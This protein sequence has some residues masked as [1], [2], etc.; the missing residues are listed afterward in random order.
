VR[1]SGTSTPVEAAGAPEAGRPDGPGRGPDRRQVTVLFADLTGFTALAERI[2]AEEI[3]AFQNALFEMLAGVITRYD[4]FVE[5]FVGDAVLAVFGAP[6]AHEDDPLRACAAALS[7]VESGDT[8]T[9]HWAERLGQPVTLHV[10]IHTGPVV[11]GNLSGAAGAAYAVTGDTVNTTARLLAAAA[12]GTIL[13]SAVTHAHVRHRFAFEPAGELPLRGKTEAV[14][15]HRLLGAL[16]EPGSARGLTGLGLVAP[17][18]GRV[19]ELD[20]L[21]AAFDRM[22]RRRAQVV[23]VVGEAGTGKS[24]LI[25][26][27]LSRLEVDGRLSGVAVRGAACSSLGESPYGV[28]GALFRA[29]YGVKATD[30]LDV[31]RQKLASGLRALGARDDEVR[32]IAPVLSYVLG[33]EEVV[34]S[35]IEPE[36]LQR[37]IA[38]AAR[39]LI[40]WRL[41]NQPLLIVIEDLH[42]ADAASVDVL[43]HVVDQLADRPLMV[44]VSHRPDTQPPLVA[45]AAQAVVQVSPLTPDETRALVAGLFGASVDV[46]ERVQEFIAARA[47][48]NPFFTEEIVRSLVGKGVLVRESDRWTCTAACEAVDVPSTLQ[49]LLL[50]RVDRLPVEPRRLLQ[51]AAVLGVVFDDTLLGAVAT[52]VGGLDAALDRLVE[53]DLIQTDGPRPEEGRYRFTHALVR[54]VV[55]QNLLVSRRSEMHERVGR[56]LEQAVGSRPER[57][58]D[59]EALGHHWSLSAD[60]VRG[61]RY[62]VTAGDRARAVY[63]ND[64]AIRHYERALQILAECPGCE[65]DARAAREQL[66]DLLGLTGRRAEALGQYEAVRKE[67][68][69]AADRVAAARVQRKLGGLQ[70]EAGDRERAGACFAAGLDLLGEDGDPIERAHLF[71]EMGR[72]AFR[73]GDNAAAIAWAERALAEAAH[74]DGAHPERTREADAMCAQAYN[75]LGVALARTGRLAEAVEQIERSIELSEARDLLQAACRGYTNL[76]VLYSSLDPRRSIETCLRGLETAKKVGDL[77]FQSRL[78]ANLAVAY[79]ALTDRCEAEGVEAAQTAIDLDRRLG[80]L[81]HLAVPLIVLGQIHQ[82]HG[83]H[84]QAFA[85]YEEARALAEQV[86]DPQL[87]FPCYDG[88]ATLHLDAG[89]QAMAAAYFAKAQE[90]CDRAGVEADALMVLPFLC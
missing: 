11:A 67:I 1:S 8:L 28:F 49:G 59:L 84:R 21:L 90:V 20:Q 12:P 29:A 7:I 66:A 32:V 33:V 61:A 38:L 31:A 68:E 35:D 77:G 69:R 47:G 34:H 19:E 53:A 5:K 43:R 82:C 26:E 41:D 15:A 18:V 37:Q 80:L 63:A 88:L 70:W 81:D 48:G 2:D 64:D 62:L 30:S 27:F 4:G 54:E 36:Q 65:V 55:Y 76:G 46:L 17:L 75:T 86:G 74:Q 25:A 51:E 13:V 45:R 89:N 60:R 44:L 24:R 6:V 14:T 10:G 40:E 39:V 42:W 71:Q 79:C 58:S 9:R 16:D 73:A 22:Q 52:P 83:E 3:R 72:L 23:S 56:A 50:S 87:L 78:Y 57:L 85:M